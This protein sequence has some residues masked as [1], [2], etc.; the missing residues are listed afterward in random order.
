MVKLTKLEAKSMLADVP[1]EF[2]FYCRDGKILKNLKE[3][4]DGLANMS[5]ETYLYHVNESK[6]DFARWV[7]DVIK[8]NELAD[9]FSS[10]TVV[11]SGSD[12]AALVGNRVMAL[13]RKSRSA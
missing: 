2:V 8:D 13:S 1:A 4:R 6:N 9:K 5:D 3:L 7:R 10:I 11:S 12:A